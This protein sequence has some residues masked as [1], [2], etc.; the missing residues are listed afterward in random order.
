M[1]IG[2]GCVRQAA[3]LPI[4][5][6]R[7]C[8]VLSRRGKRWVIPKGCIERGQTAGET[9]LQESWEEAG[10]I[11]V[12]SRQPVGSYRYR[13]CGQTYLVTVFLMAVTDAA[14]EWPEEHRRNRRWVNA[15]RAVEHITN[16]GL[17]QLLRR[18]LVTHPHQLIA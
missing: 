14:K 7:V 12:L 13:K 18:V 1:A 6:E 8:L 16:R 17:R 2:S 3:A 15:S 9:A 5:G 4:R 11:G 10:L